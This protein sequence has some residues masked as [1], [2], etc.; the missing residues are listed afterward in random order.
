MDENGKAD[1]AFIRDQL[2]VAHRLADWRIKF[3]AVPLDALQEGAK[4]KYLQASKELA[5]EILRGKVQP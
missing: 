3:I 2:R 5:D 4:E 1:I